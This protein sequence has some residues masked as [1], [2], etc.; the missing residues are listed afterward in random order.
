MLELCQKKPRH[1]ESSAH[2]LDRLAFIQDE[3]GQFIGSS[4]GKDTSVQNFRATLSK[5]SN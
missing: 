4:K 1:V 3:S 5:I 2:L